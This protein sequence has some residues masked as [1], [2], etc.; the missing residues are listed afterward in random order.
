MEAPPR[1]DATGGTSGAS[2]SPRPYAVSARHEDTRPMRESHYR[3]SVC[4][5]VWVLTWRMAR[6]GG[7]DT[8]QKDHGVTRLYT[9]PRPAVTRAAPAALMRAGRAG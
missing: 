1:C 3:G 5:C 9:S 8:P 4:V 2:P 6:P 7:T